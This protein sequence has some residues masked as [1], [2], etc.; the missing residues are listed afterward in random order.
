MDVRLYCKEASGY[1]DYDHTAAH[2]TILFG[3]EVCVLPLRSM[4]PIIKQ[5]FVYNNPWVDW[6]VISQQSSVRC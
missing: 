3:H 5:V 6:I 4:Q 1:R 2:G